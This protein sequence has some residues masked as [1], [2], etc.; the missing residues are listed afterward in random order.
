VTHAPSVAPERIGILG[1][2]FD[3]VHVG[4]LMDASAARYQLGLDRVI[5]VVARD[6]WQKRD[7]VIAPAAV[8]YEMV[9]AALDGVDGLVASRIEM[10]RDGPTYTIDTVEELTAPDRE[11]FLVMGSDV[12]AGLPTWHRVDELRERVTLAIVDREETPCVS[13]AGWKVARVS[14][15]RLELSSTDLRRRVAAGEPIEFLVPT[16]AA[17]ILH[18]HD[19]YRSA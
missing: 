17:R 15:P 18:A 9:V 16:A 7:R 19:L 2:T 10:E 14:A 3:P 4:H 5:V 1:G 11:L 6:P 13:P 12:A 8:R